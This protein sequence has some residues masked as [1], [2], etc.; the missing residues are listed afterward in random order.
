MMT[1]LQEYLKKLDTRSQEE[2]EDVAGYVTSLRV[3]ADGEVEW[4]ILTES[5]LP[6]RHVMDLEERLEQHFGIREARIVQNMSDMPDPDDAGTLIAGYLPWLVRH[7]RN[8]DPYLAA[9]LSGVPCDGDGRSLRIQVPTGGRE[10]VSDRWLRHMEQMLETHTGFR[11]ELR[12]EESEQMLAR[13]AEEQHALPVPK[14]TMAI[15]KEPS[16]KPPQEEQ[17]DEVLS[18]ARYRY[19]KKLLKEQDGLLFGRFD[20]QMEVQPV[21]DLHVQSDLACFEGWIVET[22]EPRLVSQ[23]TRVLLRFSVFDGTGSISCH[24]FV[25]PEVFEQSEED[26]RKGCYARFQARIGYDGRF[27]NDLDADLLGM[28]RAEEPEARMDD[29]PRKRVEL[30]CH[31]KMSVR[32]AVAD[33]SDV[34][35]MAVKWGHPAVAITDHGVVQAYPEARQALEQAGDS[36][37]KLIYGVE[38]YLVDDGTGGVFGLEQNRTD[39]DFEPEP[40]PIEGFVALDVETTGLNPDRDRLIEVA[41]VRFVPGRKWR[42]RASGFICLVHQSGHSAVRRSTESDR[43][44]RRHDPGSPGGRRCPSRSPRVRRGQPDLCPQCL[45]RPGLPPI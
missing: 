42:V 11:P 27:A 21:G 39:R 3:C 22:T 28:A 7:I 34:V 45:F 23:N 12:L 16:A 19:R 14:H 43:H 38:C 10:Q 24:T 37:T 30:H 5:L 41:A 26:F 1:G 36:S 32:D 31:T 25:K 2:A 6:A 18:G 13:M 33:A 40:L 29:A 9:L 4:T 15:P 20:R 35:R 44:H 8:K 17:R